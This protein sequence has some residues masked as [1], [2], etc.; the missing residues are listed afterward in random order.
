MSEHIAETVTGFGEKRVS[1]EQV[2]ERAAAEAR[3]YLDVNVPV[4][5]HLADQLLIPMALA[6]A[7]VFRTLAP[8]PHTTTNVS[9]I[10]RFLDVS[11][12]VSREEER[13]FRVEVRPR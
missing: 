5:Q 10:E 2:A 3:A 7:G 13:A 6:G 9:V 11:V 8:T 12:L 1:A 4:G